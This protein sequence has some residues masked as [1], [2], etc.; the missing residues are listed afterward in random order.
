V[1]KARKGHR[2]RVRA[3]HFIDNAVAHDVVVTKGPVV[4]AILTD[5]RG[6]VK[7]PERDILYRELLHVDI[8]EEAR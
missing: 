4:S 6:Y 3:T 2:L 1:R 7:T 8:V 5:G